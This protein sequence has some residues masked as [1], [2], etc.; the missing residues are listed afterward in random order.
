MLVESWV[1]L[2]YVVVRLLP[3]HWITDE[4]RNALPLTVSVNAVPP[5]L[6]EEGETAKQPDRGIDVVEG[7]NLQLNP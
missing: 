1:A 2:A 6:A 4:V 3:F 5:A 7:E